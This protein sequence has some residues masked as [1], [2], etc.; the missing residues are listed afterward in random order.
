MYKLHLW[1]RQRSNYT[2]AVVGCGGTGGFVAEGLCRLFPE[3]VRLMLIDHD[4]VE[5]R[6]LCRQNF[7]KGDVGRFKSEALARRL[8][9]KFVRSMGYSTVPVSMMQFLPDIIIGCVDN[10][11]ARVDIA[12]L[13]TKGHG[14]GNF[15]QGWWVDAGNGDTFGQV[16]IGNRPLGSMNKNSFEISEEQCYSLPLPTIQRPDLLLELPPVL[17]CAEAVAQDRQSPTINQSMAALVLEVVRKIFSK[18]CSWM[19]LYLDMDKG[20]L[21]PIDATPGN[22]ATLLGVKSRE[23]TYTE[24]RRNAEEMGCHAGNVSRIER[25]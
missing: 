17:G 24:G 22:V 23:L 15:F 20:S 11:K 6:N 5:E 3:S 10:G 2:V 19:A 12:E 1:E 4:R 13:I 9:E 8:S 14:Y 7:Y 18:D 21:R 16:L 25:R